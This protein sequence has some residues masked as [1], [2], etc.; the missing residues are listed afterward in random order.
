LELLPRDVSAFKIVDET[1]K[2]ASRDLF[3]EHQVL[4]DKPDLVKSIR[5]QDIVEDDHHNVETINRGDHADDD[6]D[7]ET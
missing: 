7:Y 4:V 1:G 6:D 5:E 2:W 3:L